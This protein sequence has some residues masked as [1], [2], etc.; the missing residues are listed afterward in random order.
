MGSPSLNTK[1]GSKSLLL[2]AWVLVLQIH[3]N[4]LI[5]TTKSLLTGHETP[6]FLQELTFW[7]QF[8]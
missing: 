1:I 3:M 6:L 4:I 7:Q 8:W 5:G 2:Q